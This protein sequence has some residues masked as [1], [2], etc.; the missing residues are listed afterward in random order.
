MRRRAS[1]G[2]TD[3]AATDCRGRPKEFLFEQ[4]HLVLHEGRGVGGRID[5]RPFASGFCQA[6]TGC[7]YQDRNR[8]S[9]SVFSN[10][11]PLDL[12]Q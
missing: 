8:F 2:E 11:D 4:T 9:W 1:L 5:H 7:Q 3:P 12:G 10:D 6:E